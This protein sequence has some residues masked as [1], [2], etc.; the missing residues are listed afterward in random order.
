MAEHVTK[1]T[2]V[3]IIIQNLGGVRMV[4]L[5]QREDWSYMHTCNGSVSERTN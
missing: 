3:N 2:D 4:H 1:Q 5:I